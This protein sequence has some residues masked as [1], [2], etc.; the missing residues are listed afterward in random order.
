MPELTRSTPDTI[1]AHV[2]LLR[3]TDRLLDVADEL[4]DA[5]DK[6]QRL[7]ERP[8]APVAGAGQEVRRDR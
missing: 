3:L 5:R 4:R 1:A 7:L 8:P 6:L 2:R